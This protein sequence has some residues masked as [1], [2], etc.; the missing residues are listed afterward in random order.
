MGDSSLPHHH[1]DHSLSSNG[2]GTGE[3]LLSDDHRAIGNS[4]SGINGDQP[5]PQSTSSDAATRIMKI[6]LLQVVIPL[7]SL[8]CMQTTECCRR[9]DDD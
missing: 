5:S 8:C 9:L 7:L 4:S 1:Y 6:N 3:P 2:P